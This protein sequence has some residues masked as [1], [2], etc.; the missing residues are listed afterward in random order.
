MPIVSCGKG[1]MSELYCITPRV[2][3]SKSFGNVSPA[4]AITLSTPPDASH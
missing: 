3:V 1:I 4:S 2:D